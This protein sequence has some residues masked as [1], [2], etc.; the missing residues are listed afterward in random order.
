MT[1]TAVGYEKS[2]TV[3]SCRSEDES[4]VDLT[5]ESDGAVLAIAAA[6]GTGTLTIDASDERGGVALTGRVT[7]VVVGDTG[8]A[9]VRGT[10]TGT[11]FAGEEFTVTG[12]GYGFG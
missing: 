9:T 6:A 7:S 10:F 8:V 11:K 12:C 5:A 2:F 1:V 4:S 3:M